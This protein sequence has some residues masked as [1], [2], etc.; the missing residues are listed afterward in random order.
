M[1]SEK[2]LKFVEEVKTLTVALAVFCVF[3]QDLCSR[4]RVAVAESDCS[5][6]F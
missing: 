1:A 2:I 5:E 6:R 4:D 3:G